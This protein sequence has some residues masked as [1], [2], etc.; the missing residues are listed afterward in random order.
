[1]NQF[2]VAP[3]LLR[4]RIRAGNGLID[5]LA[6]LAFTVSSW[7]LLSVLAGVNVFV[8]RQSSPPAAFVAA[9]GVDASQGVAELAIWTLLAAC[10]G[11]LLIVPLVTLGAAAARMGALGRD[12]RLSTLRL[13]G[14]TGGQAVGLSTVETMLA[15][16]VGGVLGTLG[17]LAT[18]PAWAAIGFQATPLSGTEMLLPLWAIAATVGGLV[19]LAGLSSVSGLM[20]LHISPL[21]VARRAPRPALKLWRLL[22]VPVAIGAWLVIAPMLNLAR[23]LVVSAVVILIGLGLFMGVINLVGPWLLQLLGVLFTRSGRPAVLLAGRRL[24]ADPKGAWRSVAGLAF[25]GFTGGALVSVPDFTAY[26]G[27]PLLRI[28]AADVRTGTY[29]TVGIAFLVAATS[30]LLNQASAV[31]DRRRELR[32]LA[33]LGVPRSLHDQTRLVE[34]VAPAALSAVGSGGLAMLFFAQL[35]SMAGAPIGPFLFAL[36][37]LAGVALVWAAGE[38]CRPVLRAALAGVGV[39]AE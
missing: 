14:I 36:S 31:L 9:L 17:Y 30:T 11:V 19:L 2:R 29:L 5:L 24:L 38:A 39:R 3:L 27:D 7:L 20:R 26:S 28:L 10:A 37:L 33:N 12:Q 34:V 1:M 21:G 13:L 25:V 15:A 32:Q 22:I 23:E 35:P 6:V 8:N 18:L 16:V 4:G